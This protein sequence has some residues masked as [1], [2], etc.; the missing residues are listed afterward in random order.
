MK[1]K[2]VAPFVICFKSES[3]KI[4]SYQ[5]LVNF[6]KSNGWLNERGDKLAPLSSYNS[7]D[8]GKWHILLSDDTVSEEFIELVN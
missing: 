3:N 7:D 5:R 6:L 1:V 2:E 4:K 8:S